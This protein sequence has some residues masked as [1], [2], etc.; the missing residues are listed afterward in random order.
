MASARSLRGLDGL[1]FFLAD[2]Q[3]GVG[4]FVAIV[5]ASQGLS[6]RAI[7]VALTFGGLA[8]VLAQIP[9]GA[10]VDATAR[11]RALLAGAILATALSAIALAAGP[12]LPMILAAQGLHGASTAVMGPV[13]V[14]LS[15]G[16]VTTRGELGKRLGRNRRFDS[17]GNLA[18]AG[19]M[20]LAGYALSP[21]SIFW[22]TALLAVPA[23]LCIALIAPRDIDNAAA[24]GSA[25]EGP[26]GRLADLGTNHRFLV[27]MACAVL[28]HFANASMLPLLGTVFAA[29][30]MRQSSLLL[31][32]CIMMTQVVVM[33]VAPWC[34]RQAERIGRRPLLLAGFALQPLRAILFSMTTRPDLLI[35][36][37]VLDGLAAT[38][39][40]ITAP[41]VIA[42]VTRGTGRF[43]V[44][45]GAIGT[46][47]AA[48][49]ALS[50]TVTGYIVDRFG[51]A[52]GFRALGAVAL[53]GWVLLALAMPETREAAAAGS[54][55]SSRPDDDPARRSFANSPREPR[56]ALEPR[57]TAVS[58]E[59]EDAR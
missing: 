50:T 28:F 52:A 35:A 34:G 19:L 33:L 11:K 43:N 24:R 37:Q 14:A 39:F 12:G 59:V 57:L 23:L 58:R 5:L 47:T 31:S 30:R 54:P 51:E 42:D 3:T 1:N 32:A 17:A 20:G 7:G 29:T 38:V 2:V 40:M 26:P 48:G 10:W 36:I 46:A 16:M 15:L 41:L 45:Q 44:A 4:P 18:S 56:E 6:A 22:V 21:V 9:I 27:F 55:R 49:A 13:V 25:P 8:G 53:A